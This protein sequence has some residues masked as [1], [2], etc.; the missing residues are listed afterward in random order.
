MLLC[1]G[2]IWGQTGEASGF[3][4]GF[5]RRSLSAVAESTQVQD[6]YQKQ[7]AATNPV[8]KTTGTF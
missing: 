7:K 3:G 1:I 6:P 2:S 5:R 8:F 4:F